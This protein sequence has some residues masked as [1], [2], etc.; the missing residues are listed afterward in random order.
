MCDACLGRDTLCADLSLRARKL[1][2]TSADEITAM[3]NLP[4][5]EANGFKVAV[6]NDAPYGR[7]ERISLL[8]MPISKSTVFDFKGEP[9][10]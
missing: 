4:V 3:E 9:S 2:L 1:E 5:L 8:A 10:I 6:D 7:G